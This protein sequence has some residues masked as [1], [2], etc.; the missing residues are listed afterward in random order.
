MTVL[1][2]L[3][4]WWMWRLGPQPLAFFRVLVGLFATVYLV[5]RWPSITASTSFEA[6]Q[7]E[8]IGVTHLAGE[9]LAAWALYALL[10]ATIASGVAFTLGWRHAINGPLFAVL[11]LFVLTYRNSWGQV[12]HTENLLVL[13]TL[14]LGL[15]PAADALSLDARRR[16][17][18]ARSALAYGWPLRLCA[19]ITVIT[20]L[21]TGVAKLETSGIAWVTDDILRI[22]V[23]YDN[24]RKEMLG[25]YSSPFGT[26]LVGHG[27]VFPPLAALTILVEAGAP[28]ALLGRRIALAWAAAA[29][30]FHA[31]VLATM[32]ILFAY[33][34]LGL[35]FLPLFGWDGRQVVEPARRLG[36]AARGATRTANRSEPSPPAGTWRG[37]P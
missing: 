32:T 12:F 14:V 4:R 30:A 25:D 11:L 7:F 23:A 18:P 16:A 2:P 37:E 31:G 28:A 36:R 15:V 26:W 33:P 5:I 3:D 17:L 19:L 9:P 13:H 8:P 21:I 29:W 34:L 27:W 10:L 24:L 1:R 6:R 20:Y 35:A 22:H